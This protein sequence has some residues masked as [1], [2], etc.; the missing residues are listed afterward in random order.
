MNAGATFVTQTTPT[1][2]V[3]VGPDGVSL[4][5]PATAH[6]VTTLVNTGTVVSDETST[7][8]VMNGQLQGV[9]STA[10]SGAFVFIFPTLG[11]VTTPF[12]G[13]LGSSLFTG[14]FSNQ[15]AGVN[16]PFTLTAQ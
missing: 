4:T 16:A 11:T 5:G 2:A 9:K 12:T 8:G 7:A 14:Q 13:F 1:V 3:S 15:M 10:S 6:V